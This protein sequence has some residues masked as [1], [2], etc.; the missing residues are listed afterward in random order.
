MYSH[1]GGNLFFLGIPYIARQPEFIS[2]SHH[3]IYVMYYV[4]L[5]QV[6]HD[7]V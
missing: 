5:K 2:G 7:I 6:Q 4:M 1:E 3:K